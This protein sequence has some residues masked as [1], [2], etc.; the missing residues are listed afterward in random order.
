[1]YIHSPS[2]SLQIV[3]VYLHS[4]FL[5]RDATQ[6]AAMPQYV[7]CRSVSS[8]VCPSVRDVHVPWSHRLECFEN[9]FTAE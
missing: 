7:V 1:M 4:F 5:L 9:N 2:F 6:S 8:S 3:C